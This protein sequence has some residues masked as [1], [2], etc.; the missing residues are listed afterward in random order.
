MLAPNEDMK[1]SSTFGANL[2]S[3]F[4]EPKRQKFAAGQLSAAKYNFATL[5][6]G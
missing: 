2:F 6:A 1:T 3:D 4:N 5:K